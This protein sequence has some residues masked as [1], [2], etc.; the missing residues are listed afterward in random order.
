M[1]STSF[2]LVKREYTDEPIKIKKMEQTNGPEKN[3]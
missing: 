3:A 2:Y 1:W